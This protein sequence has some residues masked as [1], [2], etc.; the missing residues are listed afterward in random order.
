MGLVR[1]ENWGLFEDL[2]AEEAA[3][4]GLIYPKQIAK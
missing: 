4:P 2:G 3:V 1:P